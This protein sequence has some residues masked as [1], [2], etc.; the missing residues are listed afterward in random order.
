MARTGKNMTPAPGAYEAKNV[1]GKDGPSL[2]MSP[3]YHDKFKERKDKL[4]PGPGNY[5]FH[6]KALKTAPNYGFGTSQRSE[7]RIGTKGVNTEVKY[8]PEPAVI[9]SKSP[10]YRF[11][12]DQ[13]KMFDEK[14][15]TSIPAAGHYTIKSVAFEDKARFHMGSKLQD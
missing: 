11:G 10:N 14:K 3:L 4:V 15:S 6:T 8:N 1:T 2:T 13:R 5:E 9:K 7:A 12:S